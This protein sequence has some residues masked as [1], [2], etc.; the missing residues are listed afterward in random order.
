MDHAL[1]YAP[2]LDTIDL[3]SYFISTNNNAIFLCDFASQ[4]S[5]NLTYLTFLTF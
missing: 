2:E 3:L 1:I 4:R 5:A